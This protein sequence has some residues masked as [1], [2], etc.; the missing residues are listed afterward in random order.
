MGLQ[1]HE[2]VCLRTPAF[3]P[4]FA[5]LRSDLMS[6][7][8]TYIFCHHR[9]RQSPPS[10]PNQCQRCASSPCAPRLSRTRSFC[11]A[12]VR[13]DARSPVRPSHTRTGSLARKGNPIHQRRILFSPQRQAAG[14]GT[15]LQRGADF[16][17]GEV[18]G[19]QK[20]PFGQDCR[21]ASRTTPTLRRTSSKASILSRDTS[22]GRNKNGRGGSPATES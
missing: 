21:L 9:H 15:K 7:G 16:H 11:L 6:S 14:L 3:R 17:P 12:C 18:R 1:P 10:L 4:G 20:I 22:Q 19:V 5:N 2:S 13:G 8:E